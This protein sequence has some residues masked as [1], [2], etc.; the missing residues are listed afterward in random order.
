MADMVLEK[1]TAMPLRYGIF[2]VFMLLA[3]WQDYRTKRINV[4]RLQ[5]FGGVG[6]FLCLASGIQTAAD[7]WTAAGV[8]MLTALFWKAVRDALLGMLPGTALFLFFKSGGE[9]GEGDCSFFLVCGWYV[10]FWDTCF[11]LAVSVFLCG[12]AGLIYYVL[13]CRMGS[14]AS[15]QR[16]K[17]QW[18]FLPFTVIPGTWILVLRLSDMLRLFAA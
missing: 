10:G 1:I 11:I 5:I 17:T 2:A 6:L 12:L 15:L 8:Q 14:S 4:R 7:L 16:G 3:A 13:G 9:I 18:P